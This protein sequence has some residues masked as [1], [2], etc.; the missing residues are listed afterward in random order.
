MVSS[1]SPKDEIWFLRVYAIT[2]QTQSTAYRVLHSWLP[3]KYKVGLFEGENQLW[4]V[5]NL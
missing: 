5:M 1:V 4:R 3:I 2:F